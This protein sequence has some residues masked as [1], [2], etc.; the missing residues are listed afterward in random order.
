MSGVGA[1][2]ERVAIETATRTSD[3]AGGEVVT[4]VPLA[5]VWAEVQS[6]SG[7]EV[8]QAER[9]EARGQYNVTI[10]FR[11]DVTAAMRLVWRGQALNIRNVRDGDG[12]RRSLII[13][14]EG[15]VA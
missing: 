2:R 4:W 10:R 15:G 1:M 3:G 7:T 9:A 13:R 12:R 5:T 6:L 11:D 14:A 8:T